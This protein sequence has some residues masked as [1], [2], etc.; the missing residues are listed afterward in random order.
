MA[1]SQ[2]AA[3]PSKPSKPSPRVVLTRVV[4]IWKNCIQHAL[5]DRLTR[6]APQCALGIPDRKSP[7]TMQNYLAAV[8]QYDKLR[9]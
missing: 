9:D 7:R 8:M 6:H 2:E 4:N 3:G 5:H 1:G